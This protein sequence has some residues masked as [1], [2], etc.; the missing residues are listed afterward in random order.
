[1]ATG[2]DAQPMQPKTVASEMRHD[3]MKSSTSPRTL[4]ADSMPTVPTEIE[5]NSRRVSVPSTTTTAV[6]RDRR[7]HCPKRPQVARLPAYVPLRAARRRI[8]TQWTHDEPN[9]TLWH[10]CSLDFMGSRSFDVSLEYGHHSCLHDPDNRGVEP[11]GRE[12]SKP[13]RAEGL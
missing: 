2:M 6:V 5:S 8:P 9:G 4:M 11:V 3:R 7:H 13:L 12:A 10:S 1:I